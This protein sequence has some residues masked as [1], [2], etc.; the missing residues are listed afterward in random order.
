MKSILLL[1]V[2]VLI[3]FGLTYL[4]FHPKTLS[5]SRS[6]AVPT[7]TLSP[8]IFSPDAPPK[9]SLIGQISSPSGEINWQSRTATTSSALAGTATV[10]Q[11]ESLIT[12]DHSSVAVNF[13]ETVNIT[14][15]SN[16]SLNFVQTLP[17]NLLISQTQGRA[18]YLPTGK[19]P[20]SVRSLHLLTDITTGD[21]VVTLNQVTSLVYLDI[22]SGSVGLGFNNRQFITQA[23]TI[24]AK[25]RVVYD[26]ITRR[27]T[28]KTL[29]PEP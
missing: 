14:I 29:P 6:F 4:H 17:I 11:G 8:F 9:Y 3:G 24:S 2:T 25:T 23:A 13:P 21:V 5:S 18:E 19:I 22:Y 16:T 20:V 1:I 26:D 10:K 7:P 28:L 15:F 27:F 12:K